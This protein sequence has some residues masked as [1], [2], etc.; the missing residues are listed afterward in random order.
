MMLNHTHD[1]K[2]SFTSFNDIV[3]SVLVDSLSNHL[4]SHQLRAAVELCTD[5]FDL[6]LLVWSIR[7]VACPKVFEV[8]RVGESVA[9]L[10]WP[11]DFVSF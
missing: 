8:V 6:L 4:L 7:E 5:I 1:V 11:S 10:G 2:H 9:I 3:Y